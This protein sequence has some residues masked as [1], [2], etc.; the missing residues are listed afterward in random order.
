MSLSLTIAVIVLADL[1]L[2][3]LLAFVMSRAGRL[4]PHLT[5]AQRERPPAGAARRTHLPRTQPRPSR[6]PVWNRS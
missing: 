6:A 2:I 4:S 5:A 1:A 3:A